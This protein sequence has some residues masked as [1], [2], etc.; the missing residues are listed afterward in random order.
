MK[1]NTL[2][3]ELGQVGEEYIKSVDEKTIH[4]VEA[5]LRKLGMDYEADCIAQEFLGKK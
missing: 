5:Y 3:E 2:S 4:A 1:D